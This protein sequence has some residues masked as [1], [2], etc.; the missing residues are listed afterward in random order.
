M[1]DGSIPGIGHNQPPLEERLAEEVAPFAARQA[2]ML[3]V[4]KEAVIVDDESAGKT[5]D[6]LIQIKSLEQEIQRACGVALDPYL[7][8]C[9]LIHQHYDPLIRGLNAA[10]GDRV[11]G[12]RGM[13]TQYV[14]K[15]EAAAE[16]ERARLAA[17]QR[18]REEEAAEASRAAEAARES[19][20]GV[21]AGELA[22][23][24][25][26]DAA[27][28]A[29]RRAAAVRVGAP[30]RSTLG[31]VATVRS[32]AYD[33]TNL[34]LVLGWAIKQPLKA[35]LEAEVRK[36]VGSYLRQ[37]GVDAVE[38]GV[39]IPGVRAWIERSAGSRR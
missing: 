8:A 37:L 13:L 16:A 26:E 30:L 38:R 20:K 15:R 27:E 18:Q 34:R 39:D 23:L 4:V 17:E 33:I 11:T 35:V 2:A 24:A 9:R 21:V 28:A 22:A 19:G 36:L 14:R 1:N 5:N 6:L 25:A 10:Y 3:A 31:Q 12:L 32:I 29:A 7:N